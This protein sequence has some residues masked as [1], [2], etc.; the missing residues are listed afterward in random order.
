MLKDPRVDRYTKNQ[1]LI[2]AIERQNIAIVRELLADPQVEHNWLN[3]L[4][5][6]R[7]CENGRRDIVALLLK[8]NQYEL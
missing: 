8:N 4:P 5:L 6:I 3:N 1:S 7:A 2:F